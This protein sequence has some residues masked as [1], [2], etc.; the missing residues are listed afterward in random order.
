MGESR[1]PAERPA[2]S[3]PDRRPR[4][5]DST[6]WSVHPL[7]RFQWISGGGSSTLSP[8]RRFRFVVPLLLGLALTPLGCRERPTF[9]VVPPGALRNHWLPDFQLLR[10]PGTRFATTGHLLVFNPG[11]STSR[12]TLTAWFEDASPR[13]WSAEAPPRA[14]WEWNT[15]GG[16]VPPNRRFALGV[17][18]SR[19]V[20]CQGTEGW[21]NTDNDYGPGAVA[22]S[23]GGP[24]E[25]ARSTQSIDRLATRWLVADG[26]VLNQPDKLWIREREWA[27]ILNPG[28][29]PARVQLRLCYSGWEKRISVLIPPQRL[30]AVAM[31]SLAQANQHYG[32]D[33]HSDIP[34][35]VQWR[36]EVRWND[37]RELMAFWSV[38]GVP[39]E[40][41]PAK[42]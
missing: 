23:P 20:V 21:T 37:E 31:D 13:T 26:I 2:A 18:S 5:W 29:Q 15:A 17:T 33:I 42:P 41:L 36:R 9:R 34:V 16:Q 19:P 27:L 35:A 14:T 3:F 4:F 32:I 30:R 28:D 38:P 24:R 40:P 1:V 12:L 6:R 11:D 7:T 22:S 25:T 10:D 39:L 8:M